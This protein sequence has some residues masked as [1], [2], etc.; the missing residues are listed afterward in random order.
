MSTYIVPSSSKYI[1]SNNS[2][3]Q[4][5]FCDH[6]MNAHFPCWNVNFLGQKECLFVTCLMYYLQPL[7]EHWSHSNAQQILFSKMWRC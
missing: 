5:L 4:K 2:F 3:N 1:A 6:E 7:I